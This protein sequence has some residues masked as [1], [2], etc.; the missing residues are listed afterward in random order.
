MKFS[1]SFVLFGPP[2]AENFAIFRFLFTFLHVSGSISMVCER[3]EKLYI[4]RHFPAWRMQKISKN[5]TFK[6]RK[7][8]TGLGSVC[9]KAHSTFSFYRTGVHSCI[10]YRK[11]LVKSNHNDSLFP[12]RTQ[13]DP[14]DPST[15][16]MPS[17]TRKELATSVFLGK[18]YELF[19]RF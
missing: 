14:S 2:Q 6:C 1:C 15:S 4:L 7:K 10:G 11:N 8:N 9:I 5:S 16:L 3:I 12:P 18:K 19:R 13:N 17:R